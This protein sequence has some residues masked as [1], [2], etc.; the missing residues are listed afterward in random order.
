MEQELVSALRRRSV[1]VGSGKGGV[2]KSTT[3]LNIA[4]I[5]AQKEWRVGL[6]DLDPL[7]NLSVIL[8]LPPDQLKPQHRE[9]TPGITLEHVSRPYAG[10]LDLVFPHPAVTGKFALFDHFAAALVER[11]DILICDLPAGIALE[12]NLDFLPFMGALVLVTNSEPPAH[13]S[14]GGYLRTVLDTRPDMPVRIWHNRYRP[15]GDNGFDPRALITNYN[16]YADE[17]LHITPVEAR[18]IRDIAFVPEDAALNLLQ[19]EPDST[20]TLLSRMRELTTLLHDQYVRQHVVSVE[21][22]ARTQDLI[23]WYIVS[24][25]NIGAIPAYLADLD[26]FLESLPGVRE[27]L[28]ALLKSLSPPDQGMRM[29][30]REQA[31]QVTAVVTH[32]HD[33]DLYKALVQSLTF[34]D[35]AITKAVD[36]NRMFMDHPATDHVQQIHT[37]LPQV[38]YLLVQRRDLTSFMRTTG[39]TLLFTLAVY[40]ELKDPE[41]HELIRKLIPRKH[42]ARG[43]LQ[44][45]RHRQISRLISRNGSYHTLFFQVL[46]MIFPGITGSVSDLATK[47][48]LHPL[49]LRDDTGAVN[50]PAYLTLSTHLLHDVVNSGLGVSV[51]ASDNAA[52]R[53]IRG[54]VDSLVQDRSWVGAPPRDLRHELGQN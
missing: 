41:T 45:D 23:S 32:L 24:N 54:G 49:L 50:R 18:K 44:R 1:A 35:A 51:S 7:S 37:L 29:L 47:H 5:L 6:V 36:A 52:S 31:S 38:L 48:G 46:R 9:I 15:A 19:T 17:A 39:A 25:R 34:L 43:E 12:E 26:Q 27:Q 16:R 13:V 42:S 53:A 14:A 4:L 33:D 28:Q 8:D 40:R 3:A 11:Y 22:S 30:S 21:V 2:G 10:T 20:V